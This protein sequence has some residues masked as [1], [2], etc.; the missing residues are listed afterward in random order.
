MHTTVLIQMFMYLSALDLLLSLEL[1]THDLS[2]WHVSDK[3]TRVLL[4]HLQCLY[5][6]ELKMTG[7]KCVRGPPL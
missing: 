5:M 3:N 1:L 7:A 4:Q 2:A 6:P